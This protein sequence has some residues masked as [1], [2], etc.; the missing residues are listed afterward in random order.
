MQFKKEQFMKIKSGLIYYG[1]LLKTK[2]IQKYKVGYDSHTYSNYFCKQ[3]SYC[4]RKTLTADASNAEI[5]RRILEGKPLMVARYGSTELY[6][7][8]ICDLNY[9]PKYEVA[10]DMLVNCSGF[11]PKDMEM[12][13]RFTLIMT[14]ASRQVDLLAFWNMF[15]EEYYIRHLMAKNTGLIPL[16]FLEPW[17]SGQ[18]W[19]KAL[20]GKKVLVIHPYAE[21]IERQYK[22]RARLFDNSDSLPEFQLYTVKAVQSLGGVCE[23]F[24]TWFDALD[25]MTHEAL[26][27][28][29]DVALI[30][31][32]AYGMP[33]AARI[34]NAGKQAIHMGG[35]LQILFGI[36]GKRW[37]TDPV[38][39]E[40]Y[41]DAW[42]RPDNK[43]K[44]KV[45]DK[46]EGGC[47][48]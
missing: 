43:D 36:K 47:Y 32:G 3:R 39:S 9:G 23:A 30:G 10:L 6:N 28:D 15:R 34:K 46:V 14:E 41:N 48:W 22:K 42:V 40:L 2:F 37:D 38:V 4:N 27:I 18:P 5:S 19:T 20:K 33:L 7:M 17:F 31:C 29:F 12:L 26:K 1:N 13:S 25:W 45:A 24:D 16:R 21:T 8:E 35:V 11:F 44:P